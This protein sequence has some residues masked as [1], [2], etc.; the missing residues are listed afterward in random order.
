M[1]DIGIHFSGPDL[2]QIGAGILAMS[3]PPNLQRLWL[4]RMG[5]M[6]IAQA[7]KNVKDQKTVD[8]KPMEPRKRKP[9]KKRRVYHKDRSVT[10][11]RTHPEMLHDL[12]KSKWLGVKSDSSSASVYFFRNV[13]YVGYKHQYGC[14]ELFRQEKAEEVF[15]FSERDPGCPEYWG[16]CSEQHA[17][18]LVAGGFPKSEKWIL[19]NLSAGHAFHI[20]RSMKKEW[21]IDGTA[22]PF[23]G[24]D[25]RTKQRW[26]DEL[27]RG[28]YGRFKAKNHSNLLK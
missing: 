14:S 24:I 7:Q 15:S 1:S 9:P 18:A 26:G 17:A 4:S 6:V 8:G 5:K 19:E 16:K 3:L 23:L 20:L 21:K 22:R 13:G 11:K 28:I 25:E 2:Q 12:V 27:M 10:F